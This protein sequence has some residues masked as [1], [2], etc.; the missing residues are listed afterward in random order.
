MAFVLAMLLGGMSAQGQVRV[1]GDVYG[2]GNLADVGTDASDSTRVYILSGTVTGSVYGGGRGQASPLVEPLV[3]GGVHVYIGQKEEGTGDISGSATIRGNVFGCNNIAGTPRNN[4]RVDV[5]QTA[6]TNANEVDHDDVFKYP[7]DFSYFNEQVS[8]S[9]SDWHKNTA[10]AIQAVYGGGNEAA[11]VP[12]VT[13]RYST[14]VFIHNCYNTVK[15]VYGGGRAADVG[16]VSG[17][18]TIKANVYVTIEGG[19]IDT[20]FGGGDGHTLT[21]PAAA[22]NEST[23]PYRAANIYGN[24][25][26]TIEGG[27][28]T[29][30]FAGSNTAGDILGGIKRL[31][32]LKT[33]P[34]SDEVLTDD[35]QEEYIISLFGG[36]NEAVTHGNVELTVGCGVDNISELYGGSNKAALTG[37][38]TLNVYGGNYTNVFGGSKGVKEEGTEGQQG[39][40]APVAANIDGNVTLNLYGGTMENAFGGSNHN[41]NITGIITVNV[42]DLE[43]ACKLDVTNIYGG[44]NETPYTPNKV[45]VSGE[46]VNPTSPRVNIIHVAA[47]NTIPGIKGSVYGGAKGSSATVESNPRVVIGAGAN[48][49][50]GGDTLSHLTSYPH[51]YVAENVY[52]GGDAA[53]VTGNTTV[54]FALASSHATDVFGGGNVATVSGLAMVDV[55]NGTATRFFGGGNQANVGST[56]VRMTGGTVSEVFGGGNNVST[57]GVTGAVS[58]YVNNAAAT[59]STITGGLYGGCNT[60]GTVGGAITVDI[61][62]GTIGTNDANYKDGVYGGGYGA[63][64]ATSDDVTVTIGSSSTANEPV[65]YGDVYAGSAQG[66]INATNKHTVVTLNKGTIHGDLYGGGLG[67][68]SSLGEGHADHAAQVNGAVQVNVNGGTVENVFGCNNV[69]GAPQS[70][71]AVDVA[72][73]TVNHDVYGGGNNAAY[74]GSPVVTIK[75][76]GVVSGNVFGGGYGAT[77]TVTGNPAVY[78]RQGASITGNVYGGGNNGA[79]NGNSSVTIQDE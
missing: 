18:D 3:K 64:T 8:P 36:S 42:F 48:R 61:N 72:A 31:T 7:H 55:I 6:H 44:G 32:V 65:I 58:V 39:Y 60:N 28:F 11:Y 51:P 15:M 57:G 29:A 49:T 69:N 21:N 14:T 53:N 52:G 66:N 63:S 38:V 62:G 59:T 37:N 26:S 10:F 45:T 13:N 4:V 56:S 41:G 23:N 40:V 79:V 12:A 75:G 1:D 71:V 43:H 33:G 54:Q 73:G 47:K 20:L 68:L 24:A 77:A 22:W 34:C 25:T 76:T 46:Q 50:P 2:G 70:T 9:N 67:D 17:S 19:R 35:N 78:L 27:Y 30:A 74:T 16:K 5:W